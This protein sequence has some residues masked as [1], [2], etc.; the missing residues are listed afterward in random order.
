MDTD[1][2]KAKANKLFNIVV[3]LETIKYD[4]E[5][6]RVNQERELQELKERQKTQ[7]RQKALKKGLDPEAL[8]G[9]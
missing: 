3:Q 4:Y 8:V 1:E 2:L 6:K 5:Q 7:L 9:K